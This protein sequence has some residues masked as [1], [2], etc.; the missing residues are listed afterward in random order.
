[1]TTNVIQF[2]TKADLTTNLHPANMAAD[3]TGVFYNTPAAIKPTLGDLARL[4]YVDAQA[5]G[6]LK[7]NQAT[8]VG[9]VTIRVKAGTTILGE[10]SVDLG[11][12]GT[13][14]YAVFDL[15]MRDVKGHTPI[16]FEIEGTTAAA[17][18]TTIDFVGVLRC[19]IP[20]VLG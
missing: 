16:E 2:A 6:H 3:A 12:A 4:I 8:G 11:G 17:A 10:T 14:L 13:D 19:G 18:G 20:I 9:A 1:M 15:Y 7:L 5:I